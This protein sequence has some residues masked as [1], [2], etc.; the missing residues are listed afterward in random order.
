MCMMHWCTILHMWNI[1]NIVMQE[2][3]PTQYSFIF[4][5]QEGSYENAPQIINDRRSNLKVEVKHFQL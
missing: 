3:E 1:V 2:M 5:G 4:N